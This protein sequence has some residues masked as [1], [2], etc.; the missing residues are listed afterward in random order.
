MIKRGTSIESHILAH[1]SLSSLL[2]R[3]H[4]RYGILLLLSHVFVLLSVIF[5]LIE[6]MHLKLAICLQL[7]QPDEQQVQKLV[8]MSFAEAAVRSALEAVNGDEILAIKMLRFAE[9]ARAGNYTNTK[10]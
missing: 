10:V 8:E 3:S 9:C 4:L 2:K 1:L 7:W 5:F 6:S